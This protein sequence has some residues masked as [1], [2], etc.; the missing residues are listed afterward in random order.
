M[1]NFLLPLLYLL[2]RAILCSGRSDIQVITGHSLGH[3]SLSPAQLWRDTVGNVYV[4]DYDKGLIDVISG[5]GQTRSIAPALSGMKD[6]STAIETV[7]FQSDIKHQ[8]LFNGPFGLVGDSN[9]NLYVSEHK[10]NKVSV[11]SLVTGATTVI[12]GSS[13]GDCSG[14]VDL[15]EVPALLLTLCGPRGLAL[16]QRSS[17]LYVADSSNHRVVELSLMS[18]MAKSIVGKGVPGFVDDCSASSAYLNTPYSIWLGSVG[19]VYITDSKN[20]RI[21]VWSKANNMV[22]SLSINGKPFDVPNPTSIALNEKSSVIYA[23]GVEADHA[24]LHVI[25]QDTVHVFLLNTKHHPNSPKVVHGQV[26]VD[27][28]KN[29]VLLSDGKTVISD[30]GSIHQHLQHLVL[31]AQEKQL[32]SQQLEQFHD[33]PAS[34]VQRVFR[35]DS[36]DTPTVAPTFSPTYDM[37]DIPTFSPTDLISDELPTSVPSGAPTSVPS[38]LPTKVPTGMPS[39]KSNVFISLS[40]LTSS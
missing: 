28:V 21:R 16:D 40:L 7:T 38:A 15:D 33:H 29:L 39:G 34:A 20:N 10:G 27:N 6:D 12:A 18:M 13:H 9:N 25:F 3:T 26:Y 5:D 4:A 32:L 17:L 11:T 22:S 19:D 2:I 30:V 37:N 1:R 31:A 36:L 8:A 14:V 23:V 35:F 24:V